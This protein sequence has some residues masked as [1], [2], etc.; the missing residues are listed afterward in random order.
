M[1]ELWAGGA[2]F[3]SRFDFPSM[4]NQQALWGKPIDSRVGE[5]AVGGEGVAP[6]LKIEIAGHYGRGLLVALSNQRM[7]VLV[8]KRTQW[9]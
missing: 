6:L 1:A 4:T 8:G 3:G 2:T 7:V 9:L 5:Q